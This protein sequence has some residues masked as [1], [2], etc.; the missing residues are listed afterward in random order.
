M[1]LNS[2]L[3]SPLDAHD[4]PIMNHDFHRPVADR[5]DRI[6]HRRCDIPI[7]GMAGLPFSV[8]HDPD[9]YDE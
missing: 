1:T 3:F 6:E 2:D 5:A 4:A 7:D 8:L 9:P